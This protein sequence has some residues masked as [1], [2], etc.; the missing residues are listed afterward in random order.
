MKKPL[1]NK[2]CIIGVGLIGGS[3]GLAIKRKKLAKEVVGIPHRMNPTGQE[4]LRI[5]AIDSVAA[6]FKD[7]AK[8]ADLV[9]LAM[10]ILTNVIWMKTHSQLLNEKAIVIDVGSTKKNIQDAAEKHLSQAVFV[11]CHPMAGSEKKGIEN[12]KW[13]LFVNANCFITTPHKKIEQLWRSVGAR[14]IVLTPEEH[15][16]WV[17]LVS[18]LPHLLAFILLK[19]VGGTVNNAF[20]NSIGY[21]NPSFRSLARIAKSNPR[22]WAD[23]LVSNRKEVSQA[24]LELVK[25]LQ[26]IQAILTLPSTSDK[27]DFS[28]EAHDKLQ[29]IILIANHNASKLLPN[30]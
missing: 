14:P 19:M 16:K 23:I 7:G 20:L 5:K 12:A 26:E 6:T 25:N 10:P 30:D 2:V 17:A 22:L 9:I 13:N 4:A 21:L 1:F 18:H 8:D 28:Q 3:L 11:G 29:K 27:A 24:I 15:D